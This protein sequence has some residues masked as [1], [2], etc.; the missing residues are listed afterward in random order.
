MLSMRR[1]VW[2]IPASL[3]L[4][5]ST[6]HAFVHPAHEPDGAIDR[7]TTSA[8]RAPRPEVQQAL[9]QG[10][11]WRD[12]QGRYGQWRAQ[13]NEATSTPHR[14]I[15]RAIPL[16]GFAGDAPSA[17]RA[18]RDFIASNP[19]VFGSDDGLKLAD[20]SRAGGVWYV[21][22]R[23]TVGGIPLLDSDWEFRIGDNGNLMAFGADGHR[24]P[25][26]LAT[27]PRIGVGVAREAAR[28]GISFDPAT[29]RVEGEQLWVLPIERNG[30]TD[31]RVV[32]ELHVWTSNPRHHWYTLVDATSGEIIL[33]RDQRHFAITG[34]VS[35]TVHASLPSDPLTTLPLRNVY[36]NSGATQTF[37]DNLGN[38]SLTVAGSPATV[39]SALRG[40]YVNV[41][42]CVLDICP[43]TDASFSSSTSNPSV[44]PI[45]WTASNSLTSERDAYYHVNRAH[46][47]I[48]AI[49]PA[50][51]AC[52]YEIAANVELTDNCNAFWDGA[53]L[54]FFTAG[55]GCPATAQLPDVIY[56]EYGHAV[57]DNLYK[58]HGRPAGMDN[59]TLQEGLAD[60]NAAFVLDDP[61]IGNDFFGPGTSLRTIS[62]TRRWP[63]DANSVDPQTTGLILAGAMW[64][65]RQSVGLPIAQSL[66]HFA[67][68]GL[69]DDPN[70]GNAFSEYFV[71][72][73]VADDNDANLSNG[74]PHSTQIMN[75]FN[76]HGIGTN[77]F[78]HI[79]APVADQPN[80]GPF[81]VNATI[82]YSGPFGGLGATP[83]RLY[84]SINNAAFTFVSMFP[85]GNPDEYGAQ[86]P[87]KVSA[88]FRY[89]VQASTADGGTQT[90]PPS[91]PARYHTFLGGLYSVM[92]END[93]DN[94]LGWT[95]G[96][97][98]DAATSGFWVRVDPVGTPIQ[99]EDDHS[100]AGTL[101]YVTGNANPGDGIGVADVDGGKTSLVSSTFNAIAGG[102]I[103]PVVSYWRWFSNNGG[104]NPSQDPWKVEISNNGGTSWVTVENTLET[105]QSWRRVMF[106]ISDYVTPTSNMKL[107]FVA[108]D[109]AV[110]PSLVEGAVD[111]FALYGYLASVGVEDAPR[112][113]TF[114]LAPASPNPFR[115][116]TRLNYT[117]VERGRVDLTV[118]DLQGRVIR[119]LVSAVE[120]LGAHSVQWNGTDRAGRPVAAG[121]YFVRLAQ[122]GQK[123][124]EAVIVVR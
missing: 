55:S 90:E 47:W 42:R 70:D 10:T 59:M 15:G 107:R 81:P 46:D 32:Y 48:K 2:A 33:R 13:W 60:V 120:E 78:V 36:V 98:G 52:D 7:A 84:Y 9:S 118:F 117:L 40:R 73:L 91:A 76:A 72:V 123:T 94:D 54:N 44:K 69:P 14:A 68:Y 124:S 102:L 114:A 75:A 83:P 79:S 121:P 3:A 65:L 19:S 74:T 53:T 17:D 100:S 66:Y 6:A 103:R 115:G 106:F 99:P 18:V 92:L 26:R 108:T 38:Y 16:R 34:N 25:A 67:R 61:V 85:T 63:V 82:T 35:A 62:N 93:F 86:L 58:A 57:N 4:S 87:A 64:D 5:V 37:T 109:D 30:A 27:T 50:F 77:F 71:E 45:P 29:D 56:H 119:E 122:S 24:A 97:S 51:T 80:T 88:V 105:D 89:Y 112:Q 39:T 95:I 22:Y 101:C 28:A 49:D 31:Y 41:E 8:S 104:D 21:R 96:A 1:L 12:F 116:T 110:L 111:D 113:A 23:Q 43:D 20:A 11:A